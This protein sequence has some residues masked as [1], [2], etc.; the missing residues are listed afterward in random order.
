VAK[1]SGVTRP[2]TLQVEWRGRESYA[3]TWERQRELHAAR[4]AGQAPDML[5][6]VEHEPVIT[7]GKHGESANLMVSEDHLR[8]LGFEFHRVE[9]GG[10]ITYHGPGQLVGYPILS[11]RDRGLTPR[12]YVNRLEQV[13]IDTVAEYGVETA[14]V[15]G[16]TGIWHGDE[17][18][19]AI[20]VAIRGGVTFHGFALNVNPDLSHFG[21]IVPCGITGRQVSSIA[22][23]TGTDPGL[24]AVRSVCLGQFTRIFDFEVQGAKKGGG[25]PPPE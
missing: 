24:D 22:R 8:S 16:M 7:L 12:E 6:L 11:L 21:L 17:K 23:L 19:A 13:L 14:R 18:V 4:R 9:R 2:G 25:G 3:V 1:I 20:G 10:D 5:V 15:H